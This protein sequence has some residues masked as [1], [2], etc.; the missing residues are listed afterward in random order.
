MFKMI[1]KQIN[2]MNHFFLWGKLKH[3]TWWMKLCKPLTPTCS[4]CVV[5]IRDT[6]LDI[7]HFMCNYLPNLLYYSLII[8]WPLLDGS[9]A[10]GCVIWVHEVFLSE[11]GAACTN[12]TSTLLLFSSRSPPLPNVSRVLSVWLFLSFH[13]GLL[14]FNQPCLW[15]QPSS[16]YSWGRGKRGKQKP[17]WWF[18]F[19]S[20]LN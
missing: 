3:C 12:N 14:N 10:L 20:L 6:T 16:W 5:W 2:I 1:Q 7:A 17:G 4:R 19:F 15:N 8:I 18:Y 11:M 13:L 9:P